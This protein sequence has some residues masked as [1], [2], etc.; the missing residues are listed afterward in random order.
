[1]DAERRTHTQ[2]LVEVADADPS[3]PGKVYVTP[4]NLTVEPN[5]A[6]PSIANVPDDRSRVFAWIVVPDGRAG[7]TVRVEFDAIGSATVQL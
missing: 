7:E 1:M 4:F 3:E 2:T 6:A 5:A